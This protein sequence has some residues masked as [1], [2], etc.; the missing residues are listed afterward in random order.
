MTL[1]L[2]FISGKHC[3]IF[4]RPRTKEEEEIIKAETVEDEEKG[5]VGQ[6]IFSYGLITVYAQKHNMYG[7]FVTDSSSNGTYINGQKLVKVR[8]TIALLQLKT[9]VGF[10]F[11]FVSLCVSRINQLS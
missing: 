4:I 2:P 8:T 7:V 10:F 5:K 9:W 3:C 1:P 11:F 6:L